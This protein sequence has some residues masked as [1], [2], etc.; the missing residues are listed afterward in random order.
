MILDAFLLKSEAVVRT[1]SA[2][3]RPCNFIKKETLAQVFSCEFCEIS[4]NTFFYRTPLLVSYTIFLV[5][6]LFKN[7]NVVVL[8]KKRLFNCQD[9]RR[10]RHKKSKKLLHLKLLK[11]VHSFILHK[12]N[13]GRLRETKK[14][15]VNGDNYADGLAS[16]HLSSV[17]KHIKARGLYDWAKN[18]NFKCLCQLTN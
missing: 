14:G 1:C 8:K 2:K 18:F 15:S 4:K 6:P 10:A 3:R 13:K 17:E 11:N 9:K 12:R 16:V 5:F 7:R